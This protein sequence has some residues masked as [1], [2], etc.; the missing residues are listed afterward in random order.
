MLAG[1]AKELKFRAFVK[2]SAITKIVDRA[3]NQLPGN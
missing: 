3:N 1:M 2:H